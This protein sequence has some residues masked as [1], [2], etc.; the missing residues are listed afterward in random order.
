VFSLFVSVNEI[1]EL[2]LEILNLGRQSLDLGSQFR[3]SLV[4]LLEL[5]G[6]LEIRMHSRSCLVSACAKK[7]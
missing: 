7:R 1:V 6:G 5:D 2:G 3:N 4:N